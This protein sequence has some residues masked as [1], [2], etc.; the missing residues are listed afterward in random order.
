MP[1]RH[2]L[3]VLLMILVAS[4]PLAMAEDDA[5]MNPDAQA[6]QQTAPD[7]FRVRYDTSAGPVVIEVR[8]DWAPHGADRFYALV[9]NGFYDGCRF[10]RVVPGF[11]VQWGINGDPEV[12]AVW[13]EA[14]IPDDAVKQ[15]NIR[16]RVTFATSGPDSRTTQ[17]FIN[18][19]DNAGLNGMGFAP[20][21]EV[22]EGM[23]VV[24]KIFAGYGERPDQGRIQLQGNAY[25]EKDFPKLDY[26]KT[27]S[28]IEDQPKEE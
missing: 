6:N 4:A 27:A 21:G 3:P 11:V 8:R 14:T 28:V 1:H 20:F 19:N 17:L 18:L 13:R 26:I 15:S 16:G 2:W 25:L 10:F 5:L 9:R 24:D 22:V 23:D 12:S 7:V